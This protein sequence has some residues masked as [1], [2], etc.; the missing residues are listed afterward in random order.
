MLITPN[1]EAS[2]DI[3]VPPIKFHAD[4]GVDTVAGTD[5][6]ADAGTGAGTDAAAVVIYAWLLCHLY[7]KL[8]LAADKCW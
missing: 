3:Q 8:L 2:I 5:A 6:G 7:S 4:F 1:E